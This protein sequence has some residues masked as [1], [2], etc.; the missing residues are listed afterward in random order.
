MSSITEDAF[1]DSRQRLIEAATEAFREEGYRASIDRI[2][3]KAGVARQT[4]YNHF[5]S[6]DALFA[7]M[8]RRCSETILVSLDA[9]DVDVRESLLRFC[10]VF[11]AKIIGDNGLAAFRTLIAEATRFP[12]LAKA[13][14]DNGPAQTLDRLSDFLRR[15]MDRGVLRRD[16]PVFAAETLLGMLTGVERTHRLC[17][18]VPP[19]P[20]EQEAAKIVRIVDCFLLAFASE[21]NAP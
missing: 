19:L 16:D 17:C 1:S 12:D 9:Q 4:L 14:Y 6:K 18:S 2:A 20:P 5:P 13:F 10:T 21:R 8:T 3:A 11:R 7:E 15:A